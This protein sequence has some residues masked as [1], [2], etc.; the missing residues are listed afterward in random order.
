MDGK[1]KT[2]IDVAI[3]FDDITEFFVM[4]DVIDA[5]KKAKI[6]VDIVVPYDSGYNGLAEH[7]Q[8]K[9]GS[10]GYEVLSDARPNTHYKILFTPYDM[11]SIPRFD[12]S[13][14]INYNYGAMC[15]KPNPV[16][17]PTY[18]YFY[19]ASFIFN[20]YE[21]EFLRAYGIKTYAVPDWRFKDFKK[22]K[23][24]K[25]QKPNLVLLPTF[26]DVC[27]IDILTDSAISKIKE[28]YNVIAKSH[29]AIHFRVEEKKR[30]ERL[31]KI[32]DVFYDSDTSIITMLEQA[33]VVLSDNSAA[34]FDTI[35]AGVPV[36]LLSEDPNLRKFGGVNTIQYEL[37]KQGIIPHT[38]NP[39]KIVDLIDTAFKLLPKQQKFKRE[40]FLSLGEDPTKPFIDIT[41]EFLSK[42]PKQDTYH[43]LHRA[44]IEEY[45]GLKKHYRDAISE[46]DAV[47]NSSS[48]KITRPLRR[49][50]KIIKKD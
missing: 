50:A 16:W 5:M 17:K 31:E 18:K 49:I 28:K 1:K 30:F 20:T 19:D 3:I 47:Y 21:P 45:D 22:H 42:D 34:I 48:W 13:Y 33:D 39:E 27:C 10:A 41:K 12:Y 23:N 35:V 2:I 38:N 25:D 32:A 40:N 46:R 37:I 29:H 14:H 15:T 43:L 11:R 6:K 4:R 8:E 9:I 44:M 36:A 7:T 26:G 24:N